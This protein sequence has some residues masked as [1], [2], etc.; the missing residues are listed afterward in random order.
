MK[1]K[2]FIKWA[3]GKY[4]LSD[5]FLK[6]LPNIDFKKNK[7]IEPMVGSGGFLFNLNPK[8]AY[9][10]DINENLIYTYCT[11][12]DN[13]HELI[14]LLELYKDSHSADFYYFQRNLYNKLKNLDENRLELSALFIYLNKTC[15]N[16]LY[17]ENSKGDFNV[18][19]GKDSNDNLLPMAYNEDNLKYISKFLKNKEIKCHGYEEILNII[20][21]GDFVYLDPPYIPLNKSSFTKYS[22]SDFTLNNH[23]KLSN[24]CS[25][26]SDLGAFF[27]L[28]NSDIPKTREIYLNNFKSGDYKR[29]FRTTTVSRSIASKSKNRNYA[30]EI[31]ITNYEI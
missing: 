19:L 30:S 8:K 27:M 6:I 5:E 13:V 22:K 10:S 31:I 7:Y 2:P 21:E 17:R 28:S 12:R 18:P 1:I 23:K 14:E 24:F 11:I 25:K 4:R 3:G 26:L 20:N 15:F 16:G 9:I 29:F